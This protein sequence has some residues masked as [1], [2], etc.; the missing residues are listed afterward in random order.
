MKKFIILLIMPILL[1]AFTVK[2]TN[3]KIV[4]DGRLEKAWFV[5]TPITG[6]IQTEPNEGKP[7]T[8]KTEVYL[9]KD[10][11]NLYVAFKCFTNGR[12]PQIRVRGWDEASGDQVTVFLDP[13]GDRRSGYYFTV[14]AAGTQEDGTINRGGVSFDDSWDG[15]W[16][17]KSRVTDY[18]YC[19]EMEI[20]F[21]SI[22]YS[23]TDWGVQFERRI[24]VK[25]EEDYW[26]PVHQIPG[27]R[28]SQFG[29]INGIDPGVKGRFLEI[30]PVGIAKYDNRFKLSGGVDVSYNP[31]SE[32]GFNLTILPDFAQIEA[33]PFQVNLSRHALYLEERR[34]F[35]IEGQNMFKIGRGGNFNFGPPP[36]D[37]LYTRNIGKIVNDSI[38]VPIY[39][40]LK[41]TTR[42]NG[43]EGGAM[44][45]NTGAAGSEP[46]AHYI[47]LRGAK[48]LFPGMLMGVTYTGKEAT[49]DYTR[50]LTMDGNY[51]GKMGEMVAQLSYADSV[52]TR[53]FAGY[54]NYKKFTSKYIWGIYA[55]HID[56]TYNI[57]EVGYVGDKGESFGGAVASMSRPKI[58][59]ISL[60]SLVLGGGASKEPNV[61]HYSESSFYM[62][63]VNFANNYHADVSFGLSNSYDDTSSVDIHY[64]GRNISLSIM[65]DYSKALSGG[66]WSN[67][68]YSFNYMAYHLGYQT[69]IGAFIK[70]K[71]VANLLISSNLSYTGYWE[72]STG[73][74]DILN[75]RRV[76]DSYIITRP[77]ISYHFTT[78]LAASLESEV[79][80][81]RSMHRIYE[82]RLNPLIVYNFSPKS[83]IYLVYS[84]TKMYNP[85]EGEFMTTDKG[86]AFKIRYLLYF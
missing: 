20:P 44:Y 5:Q 41:F 4:I 61:H 23:S 43:F 39:A 8:E 82:Y 56:S 78:K 11:N 47:A 52:G 63:D 27:L 25:G 16:F 80:Y 2:N 77:Y 81:E 3:Q 33:D 79:V 31:S 76:E 42:G 74:V 38:E 66:M 22:R 58:K 7:A 73:I 48:D 17:A 34:P 13:Y 83:N 65:S 72:D 50:I 15:V 10:K 18:G 55:R 69:N 46:M 67:L 49:N 36:I 37:I 57:N 51:T 54:I 53:G 68:S 29:V 32:F 21:K 64:T 75:G 85:G 14:S 19:V 1:N 40:G 30:Y 9:L 84:L 6:F 70:F 86:A 45:V 71:P 12:K 24:P 26:K 28:M 62:A 60:F 35:F 59:S